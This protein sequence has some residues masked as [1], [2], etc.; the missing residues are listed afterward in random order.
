HYLDRPRPPDQQRKAL[1]RAAAR[2]QAE[3]NLR[4]AEDGPFPA[5]EPD[6]AGEC[7]LATSSA[8]PTTDHGDAEDVAVSQLDRGVA[9]ARRA[10]PALGLPAAVMGE[11]VVG[12]RALEGDDLQARL[13]VDRLNQ[14]EYLVVHQIIDRVD[15][16]VIE[17]DPPISG[18]LLIDS[19]PG[20]RLVHRTYLPFRWIALPLPD[21]GV[22]F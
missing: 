19:D 12:I 4:L 18:H 8:C 3:P 16:R 10:E 17:G 11:E 5:R 20:R 6:V 2:N 15:R 9:P 7:E 22:A 1:G 14:V 13:G 21:G